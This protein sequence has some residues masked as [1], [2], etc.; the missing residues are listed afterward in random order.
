L[1]AGCAGRRHVGCED[2]SWGRFRA[3]KI[4][5]NL[6]AFLNPN[7]AIYIFYA[8]L[9]HSQ[10]HKSYSGNTLDKTLLT[11]IRMGNV[12]VVPSLTKLNY[13]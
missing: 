5:G 10:G 9:S 11:E 1:R 13:F 8:L 4:A 12:H 7:T 3:K 6:S 2:L